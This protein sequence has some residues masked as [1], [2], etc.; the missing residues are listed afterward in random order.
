MQVWPQFMYFPQA[1]R[2]K[3]KKSEWLHNSLYYSFL[4]YLCI[5]WMFCNYNAS[6]DLL[7]NLYQTKITTFKKL[8]SNWWNFKTWKNRIQKSCHIG[9]WKTVFYKQWWGHCLHQEKKQVPTPSSSSSSW[10]LDNRSSA[11]SL[12]LLG[13]A[14]CCAARLFEQKIEQPVSESTHLFLA[15]PSP[16]TAVQIISPWLAH[17]NFY[18][19]SRPVDSLQ[20]PTPPATLHLR[21]GEKAWA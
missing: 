2:L 17:H 5:N 4:T 1:I 19:C 10:Q 20:C 12:T 14:L 7:G 16:G 11:Q 6:K 18:I 9:S 3:V 13:M 21:G 8:I 15:P